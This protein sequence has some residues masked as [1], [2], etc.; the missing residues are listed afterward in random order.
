MESAVFYVIKT[1]TISISVCV[2]VYINVY[3]Y[4]SKTDFLILALSLTSCLTS[5][6]VTAKKHSI[7]F[8]SPVKKKKEGMFIKRGTLKMLK[9][10]LNMS[11]DL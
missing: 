4:I 7:E 3:D 9:I 5:V 2:R 11:L 8:K 1:F 10:K 6:V